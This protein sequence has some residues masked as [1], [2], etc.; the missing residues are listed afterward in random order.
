M[1]VCRSS[2]SLFGAGCLLIGIQASEP[3]L[4][5][6][7]PFVAAVVEQVEDDPDLI[8][9][10]IDDLSETLELVSTFEMG[11][12]RKFSIRLAKENAQ[13][14]WYTIGENVG[15]FTLLAYDLEEKALLVERDEKKDFL[16]I[17]ERT[18][19]ASKRSS[20]IG[21]SPRISPRRRPSEKAPPST[22]P[23]APRFP[24]NLLPP[25]RKKPQ[26]A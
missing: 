21:N 15:G 18:R 23:S 14:R 3:S 12:D 16:F 1:N 25:Q 22:I 11:G 5:T 6:R 8:I 26:K 4:I 17:R 20:R 2:T 10:P 9:E 7:N 19:L 13:Q 24:K